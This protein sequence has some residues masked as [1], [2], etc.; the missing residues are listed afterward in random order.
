METTTP[1]PQTI[2]VVGFFAFIYLLAILRKT[3]RQE[4]DL[5]DFFMLSMVALLPA[6]FTF[7]PAFALWIA[8]L[9]G[10]VFPFVIMFG[11][12]LAVLF[13]LVHRLTS[14]VHKLERQSRLLVQEISLV[15]MELEP[16][17]ARE[18]E[19]E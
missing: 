2:L 6:L 5:Y 12:L 3:A 19:K 8:R 15:R 18:N 14:K 11:A 10:V 13:I 16:R 1:N 7:V 9:S 4:L 17:P